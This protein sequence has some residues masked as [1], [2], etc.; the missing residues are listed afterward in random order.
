VAARGV[1]A[2]ATRCASH[3]LR[4]AG[5]RCCRQRH[6]TIFLTHG[7]SVNVSGTAGL[8]RGPMLGVSLGATDDI[9]LSTSA[10]MDADTARARARTYREREAATL[11]KYEEWAEVKDAMQT[12]LM[13]SFIY[14]PKEGL[15]APVTRNWAFGPVTVDGDQS[16]GLFCWCAPTPAHCSLHAWGERGPRRRAHPSLAASAR[17]SSCPLPAGP[18]HPVQPAHII[19]SMGTY[20]PV[21]PAHIIPSMGTYHLNN[22]HIPSQQWAHTTPS[23]QSARQPAHTILSMQSARQLANGRVSAHTRTAR[24]GADG[25]GTA[26]SRRTCSLSTR[27]ISPP[28]TS[29]RSSRDARRRASCPR[30]PRAHT[31]RVTAPIRPLQA[32]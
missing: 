32:R 29:C 3:L 28:P 11:A 27:S 16:D 1:A 7:E 2:A 18:H 19:P 25:T 13:W 24:D 12:S 20:H 17:V 22:G 23:M 26:R 31:R 30:T 9:V 14:D 21:Q 4:A 10:T 15:V 8:P 6:T 5:A